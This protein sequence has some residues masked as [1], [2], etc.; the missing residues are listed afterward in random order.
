MQKSLRA[1]TKRP[2]NMVLVNAFWSF[3]SSKLGP[4]RPEDGW[5]WRP[6]AWEGSGQPGVAC[7]LLCT[8]DPDTS[9]CG[10]R[11][12]LTSEQYV[13]KRHFRSQGHEGRTSAHICSVEFCCSQV[14]ESVLFK[15]FRKKNKTEPTNRKVELGK[16]DLKW[17]SV[18]KICT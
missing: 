13:A 8:V 6:L 10:L 16:Q 9:H 3:T 18:Y 5:G 12:F 15:L 14:P 7:V 1:G 11:H 17:H 2:L 4:C